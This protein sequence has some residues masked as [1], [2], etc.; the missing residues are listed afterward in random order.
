MY[1]DVCGS[2]LSILN[3]RLR[4]AGACK[5]GTVA[6]TVLLAVEVL[7]VIVI[8]PMLLVIGTRRG[9]DGVD[10]VNDTAG[11]FGPCS[12]PKTRPATTVVLFIGRI[13][14]G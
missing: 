11:N 1:D 9:D 5:C 12:G 14:G 10:S 7:L 4:A 13:S 8:V 3:D 6:V 2:R